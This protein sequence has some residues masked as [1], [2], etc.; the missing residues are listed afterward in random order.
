ML[1]IWSRGLRSALHSRTY[2]LCSN[3]IIKYPSF[4][5]LI[6]CRRK[7]INH[8]ISNWIRMQKWF[9]T[10]GSNLDSLPDSE[11][12]QKTGPESHRY[13][14]YFYV[15][16]IYWIIA[17]MSVLSTVKYSRMYRKT[18]AGS[19]GRSAHNGCDTS[20]KLCG[21]LKKLRIKQNWINFEQYFL[22]FCLYYLTSY[23]VPA[24]AHFFFWKNVVRPPLEF[25][26]RRKGK[27]L[28]DNL[29]Y[30]AVFWSTWCLA[31]ETNGFNDNVSIQWQC[32]ASFELWI[33][34]NDRRVKTT[35]PVS[36]FG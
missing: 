15:S 1:F 8:V 26:T 9:P 5:P 7:L 16:I 24:V 12:E 14:K 3:Y 22:N 25:E 32:P 23:F 33:S 6:F 2:S 17:T 29:N 19:V 30:F 4:C 20:T 31:R 11:S 18:T 13:I 27:D 28:V 35:E 21:K 10:P 34:C 36:L